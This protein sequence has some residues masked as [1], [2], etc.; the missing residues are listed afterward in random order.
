[1]SLSINKYIFNVSIKRAR[2]IVEPILPWLKEGAG[3]ILDFGCGLGHVGYLISRATG[4]KITY[5]DV[6]KYPNTAPTVNLEVFDGKSIPFPNAHFDTTIIIFVL[7]HT[8]NPKASL[9]EVIRVS[10]N[11]ILVCEDLLVSKNQVL[12]EV[13]K[14]TI[15][16]GFL[17]HMTLKYKT[18]TEWEALF[19][20][21]GLTIEEKTYHESLFIFKFKH[22]SWLLSIESPKN[23]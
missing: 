23:N 4:R 17:P 16:N 1:M 5:L 8:P 18:E 2:Q 3:T 21:L 19:K 22:V 6:R 14:D 9:E 11:H 7:H 12:S 10:K 15:T 20:D 13:I